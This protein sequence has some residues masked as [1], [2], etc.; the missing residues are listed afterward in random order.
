ML[1]NTIN[2]LTITFLIGLQNATSFAMEKTGPANKELYVKW[3]TETKPIYRGPSKD[4]LKLYTVFYDT[5]LKDIRAFEKTG[6]NATI[7]IE[8][9]RL[10]TIYNQVKHAYELQEAAKS[11]QQ[12]GT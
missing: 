9:E 12:K 11:A 4:G 7:A 8:Q 2:T 6:N 10:E 5:E 1:K 3:G